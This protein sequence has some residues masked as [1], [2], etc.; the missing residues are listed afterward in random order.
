MNSKIIAIAVLL[1]AITTNC[2]S[3]STQELEVIEALNKRF[4]GY[5]FSPSKDIVGTHLKVELSNALIDSAKLKS[6]FDS[7]ICKYKNTRNIAWVY[8]SVHDMNGEYLF[9]ISKDKSMRYYFS[10][11]DVD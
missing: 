4:N 9:T 11:S 8:L 6:I 5:T 1:L 3:P 10:R 2:G 7:T